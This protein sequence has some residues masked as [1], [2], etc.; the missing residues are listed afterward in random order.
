METSATRSY[1][2]ESG[3]GGH[4]R[5][6]I[7]LERYGVLPSQ[8]LGKRATR[9]G[10]GRRYK[11]CRSVELLGNKRRAGRY[12]I[13]SILSA[14]LSLV[15]Q[16]RRVASRRLDFDSLAII[17]NTIVFSCHA[18]LSLKLGCKTSSLRAPY[19]TTRAQSGVA[20]HRPPS[21]RNAVAHYSLGLQILL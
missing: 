4:E 10:C 21:R 12:L 16:R 11:R 1:G 19:K 20:P 6:E 2:K 18:A 13:L 3:S 14:I 9:H 17:N 5:A 15:Q 8:R 7:C